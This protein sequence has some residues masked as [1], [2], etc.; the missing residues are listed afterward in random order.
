VVTLRWMFCTLT[1][2]RSR[3]IGTSQQSLR[4]LGRANPKEHRLS[5]SVAEILRVV[6]HFARRPLRIGL[7]LATDTRD[8]VR[9]LRT[10]S[11]VVSE[12]EAVP[13]TPRPF[14]IR[15]VYEHT[16]SRSHQGHDEKR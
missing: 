5:T 11:R 2:R 8:W 15:V 1:M 7:G 16:H 14:G 6:R 4:T 3:S 9:D 12:L 13:I 10:R